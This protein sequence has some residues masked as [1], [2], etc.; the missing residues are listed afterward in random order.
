MPAASK[1]CQ[2]LVKHVSSYT[3]YYICVL[4]LLCVLI[5]LYMCP[6]TAMYVS[7]YYYV[8][9]HTTI[10][11]LVLLYV[12]SCY[13]IY[14]LILLHTCPHTC[15]YVS[16][17][18]CPERR[19]ARPDRRKR[20]I[21]LR[22]RYIRMRRRMHTSPHTR[23]RDLTAATLYTSPHTSAYSTCVRIL[24]HY[25]TRIR[26]AEDAEASVQALLRLY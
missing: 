14:V 22:I 19:A 5:L 10:C 13:F 23:S 3:S 17:Y 18:A 24:S 6:H 8:C 2:Q 15:T 12:S 21:R 4:M 20:Y 26:S 25:Y 7:S 11:V 16:S 1:A 9:P